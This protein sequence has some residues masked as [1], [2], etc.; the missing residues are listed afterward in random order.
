VIHP[1]G[2]WWQKS[3]PGGMVNVPRIIIWGGGGHKEKQI[4]KNKVQ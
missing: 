3:L 2:G 1:N 4:E